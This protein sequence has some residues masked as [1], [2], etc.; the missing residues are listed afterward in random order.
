M[1]SALKARRHGSRQRLGL[2][3]ALLE[4][5]PEGARESLPIEP[6]PNKQLGSIF[7][8]SEEK[9]PKTVCS[10]NSIAG[11]PSRR[12]K[13]LHLGHRFGNRRGHH[14][15]AVFSHQHIVL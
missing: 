12:G 6:A 8:L 2:R 13:R 15:V 4:E 7:L 9:R 1:S 10:S 5:P 3:R 14:V 11:I